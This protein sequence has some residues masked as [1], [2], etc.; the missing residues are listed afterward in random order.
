MATSDS[1]APSIDFPPIVGLPSMSPAYAQLRGV[2]PGGEP[3]RMLLRNIT[4]C[5]TLPGAPPLRHSREGG[6]PVS[7]PS[8]FRPDVFDLLR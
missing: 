4:A 5:F 2:Q 6:N 3:L 8:D 1:D 7:T